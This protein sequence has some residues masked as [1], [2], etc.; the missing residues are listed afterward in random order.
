MVQVQHR[1]PF[2]TSDSLDRTMKKKLVIKQELDGDDVLQAVSDY[3]LLNSP[4]RRVKSLVSKKGAK[5][6]TLINFKVP[7]DFRD[8]GSVG[9]IVEIFE[10]LEG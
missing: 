4:S 8:P 10:L 3:V 9:V 7:T 5:Y 1:P 6:E 2:Q